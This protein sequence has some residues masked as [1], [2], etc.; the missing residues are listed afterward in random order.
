MASGAEFED[1]R[2][3]LPEHLRGVV[4]LGFL[5]GWRIARDDQEPGGEDAT[6]RP[7]L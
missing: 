6:L 7:A 5:T 4:T 1:V 2:A 3:A